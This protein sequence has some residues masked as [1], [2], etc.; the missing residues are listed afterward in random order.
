MRKLR[1]ISQKE[2]RCVVGD[3][4][5]VALR[6]PELDRETTRVSCAVMGTRLASH[7]RESGCDRARLALLEDVCH[8]K[9]IQGVGGLVDTMGTGTLGVDDTLGNSLAIEM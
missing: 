8:A 5:P 9:I 7:S 1:G 2:Y 4:V 6:G 3:N